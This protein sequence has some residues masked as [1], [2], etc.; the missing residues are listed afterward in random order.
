MRVAM[1]PKLVELSLILRKSVS[2]KCGKILDGKIGRNQS[3]CGYREIIHNNY[4][5][6]SSE[7]SRNKQTQSDD[8]P[9]SADVVVIGGGIVGTSTAFHLA[10]RGVDVVLVERHK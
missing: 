1:V 2:S 10:K 3:S 7:A 5:E 9:T 4:R 8:L 6:Y